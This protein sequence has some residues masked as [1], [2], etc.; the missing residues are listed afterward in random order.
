MPKM[1]SRFFFPD[2]RPR[3]PVA[4]TAPRR[5]SGGGSA[6]PV[7][8]VRRSPPPDSGWFDSSWELR[9]GL[10]VI[11]GS[12]SSPAPSAPTNRQRGGAL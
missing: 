7:A 11:E 12:E 10:T 9:H 4:E 2:Q 1:L 8:P 3:Q 5:G 6:M